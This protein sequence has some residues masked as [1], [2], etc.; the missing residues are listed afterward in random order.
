[1]NKEKFKY[2]IGDIVRGRKI[3]KRFIGTNYIGKIDKMYGYVFE[4]EDENKVELIYCSEKTM[5]R[6]A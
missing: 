5:A 6:G 3:I 4:T 1:M 2:N